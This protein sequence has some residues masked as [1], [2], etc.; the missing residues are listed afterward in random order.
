VSK[1]R[2]KSEPSIQWVEE[3]HTS[4]LKKL[5]VYRPIRIESFASASTSASGSAPPFTEIRVETFSHSSFPSLSPLSNPWPTDASAFCGGDFPICLMECQKAYLSGNRDELLNESFE[6]M[7]W[8]SP[9]IAEM[10]QIW[11]LSIDRLGAFWAANG[12]IERFESIQNTATGRR[13]EDWERRTSV[14]RWVIDRQH[15][16]I[17]RRSSWI[18]SWMADNSYHRWNWSNVT[19]FIFRASSTNAIDD[20][21]APSSRNLSH[22]R[23]NLLS[24]PHAMIALLLHIQ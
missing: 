16:L 17:P 8:V 19:G 7:V 14:S 12:Q 6:K 21:Y 9:W 2:T 3:S 10:I 22:W 11:L 4:P 13:K 18:E 1:P 23:P 24:L 20:K 15:R 5:R